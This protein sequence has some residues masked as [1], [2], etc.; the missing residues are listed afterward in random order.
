M[1]HHDPERQI[2]ASS[3]VTRNCQVT[4]PARVRRRFNIKKGDVIIFVVEGDRLL[5]EK[6]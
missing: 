5:I 1:S 6:G 4:L 2:L 3:V